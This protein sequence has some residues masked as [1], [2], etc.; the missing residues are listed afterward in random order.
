MGLEI[1]AGERPSGRRRME[2]SAARI[3]APPAG[4][5]NPKW[6]KNRDFYEK[7]VWSK[8]I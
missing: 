3:P 4:Q 1:I 2:P 7:R 5:N 6:E 8:E